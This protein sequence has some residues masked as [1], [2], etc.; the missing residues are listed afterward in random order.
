MKYLW[1][2]LP[3]WLPAFAGDLPNP[4]D[5]PGATN[6]AVTPQ[7]I[8]STICR[9]GWT[10]TI[11]PPASYTSVLKRRQLRPGQF[12]KAYEEDHLIPLSLGGH[13]TD[14]RN[15]WPQHWSHPFGAHEK[16]RLEVRLKRDV[17]A[18]RLGLVE[19]QRMIA[20]DWITAYEKYYG[21]HKKARP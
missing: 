11:R 7:T 2:L 9:S 6:P 14:P 16:D 3:V 1:L 19:A 4:H 20:T 17:C 12:V 13:P 8:R 15:L 5:T 18:G 10:R 21:T